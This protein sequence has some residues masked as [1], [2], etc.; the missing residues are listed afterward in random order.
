MLSSGITTFVDSHFITRDK[1]C[2]DGIAQAVEEIGIRGVIGRNTGN[3]YP[4]PSEFHE[5]VAMAIKELPHSKDSKP[6]RIESMGPYYNMR[7]I[8][9]SPQMSLPFGLEAQ[10]LR[11]T[12]SA[13]DIADAAAMQKEVAKLPTVAVQTK[14][15]T[16]L[17]EMIALAEEEELNGDSDIQREHPILGSYK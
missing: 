2:Y 17:D 11:F 6:A 3:I 15:A 14:A 10:L 7:K 9:H 4:A 12:K 13:D 8:M 5:S 1:K 16:T